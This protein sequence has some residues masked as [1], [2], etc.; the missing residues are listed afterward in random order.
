MSRYK[1]SATANRALRWLTYT[2]GFVNRLAVAMVV[3]VMSI[4]ALLA[5]EGRSA[6]SGSSCCC[7]AEG[8]HRA[9]WAG[10]CC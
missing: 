2:H 10:L 4:P 1:V 5:R 8:L 3:L 7:P 9:V 6:L